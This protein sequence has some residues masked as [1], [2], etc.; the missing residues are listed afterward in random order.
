MASLPTASYDRHP[1]VYDPA[2]DSFLLLDALESELDGIRVTRP[3][4]VL[5]I[6]PGSGVVIVSLATALGE[7]CLYTAADVNPLACRLTQRCA[8]ANR[9]RVDC[10]NASLFDAFRAGLFDVVVF[11]PPYVVT[12]AGEVGGV[13][14]G[15]AWAG[16][17]EGRHVIDV[18]L[19]GLARHL[20]AGG[21]CY[22]V[23]IKDNDLEAVG[24]IA[25][26]L[27]LR[28]SVVKERKIPG[29]HLY[30]LKFVHL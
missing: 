15:R 12:E 5:E 3:V 2:E 8:H 27:G 29:E 1:D 26:E 20:S 22:M 10:V 11:N 14:I 17:K 30:V 18:F 16:G 13:G 6:G 28:M 4:R 19:S 9:V 7:S 23:A 21:V 24:R 25:G